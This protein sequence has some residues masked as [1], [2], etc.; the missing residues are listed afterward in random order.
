MPRRGTARAA[1]RDAGGGG[2]AGKKRRSVREIREILE[3]SSF[4]DSD[5]GRRL[6]LGAARTALESILREA[7]PGPPDRSAGC[8]AAG[9]AVEALGDE[10]AVEVHEVRSVGELR[11]AIR[12]AVNILS[13]IGGG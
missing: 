4:A 11:E 3:N 5:N 7:S 2:T 8:A 1:A 6:A 12:G 9:L 13:G 10:L